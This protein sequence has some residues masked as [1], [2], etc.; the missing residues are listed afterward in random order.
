[1]LKSH[2]KSF[3]NHNHQILILRSNFNIKCCINIG[4]SVTSSNS[5]VPDISGTVYNKTPVMTT[6]VTLHV[7]TFPFYILDEFV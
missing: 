6:P 2:I 7:N 1:M 5:G 4:V 3:T